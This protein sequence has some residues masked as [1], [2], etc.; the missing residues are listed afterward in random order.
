MK[1]EQTEKD[2]IAGIHPVSEALLAN[3]GSVKKIYL[4]CNRNDKRIKALIELA[5]ARRVSYAVLSA[6]EFKKRFP[7]QGAQGVTAELASRRYALLDELIAI[8]AQKKE[9]PFFIILDGIEDPRNFGGIIRSAE[10]AGAHG[11]VFP[12]YRAAGIGPEAYKSSSG[13]CEYVPL[14]RLAN[15]KTA[16][17]AFKANE[18]TL[19]G[20]VASQGQSL[21]T[22]DFKQPVAL[23]FGSE[24]KGIKRTI[25]QHCD[26]LATIPMAGRIQSLN[27]SVAAGIFLFEALR[28]RSI[29][30]VA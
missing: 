6:E 18:I 16:I 4:S 21:W 17:Q 30:S 14:C 9:A 10:A 2:Y 13:A 11:I 24:G 3:M 26:V 23:V 29:K 22:I 25:I 12:Y 8:P 27:A 15:V 5:E 7:F 19:V 1:S 20:A 28:Q